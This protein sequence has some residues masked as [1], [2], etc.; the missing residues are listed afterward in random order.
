MGAKR[1]R[2]VAIDGL[3]VPPLPAG[4][5]YLWSWFLELHVRRG[6]GAMGAA[7]LTWPDLS[8]WAR[9]TGRAP[10]P[11]EFDVLTAI[12]RAYLTVSNEAS[13]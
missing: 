6:A 8:A 3:R 4:F 9:C 10:R 2:Q 1:G 12:D 7:P 11:W 5:G 13:Q